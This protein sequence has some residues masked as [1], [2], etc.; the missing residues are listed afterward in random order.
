MSIPSW[1]PT[2]FKLLTQSMVFKDD[3]EHYLPQADSPS[4]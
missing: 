2:T 3:P 1:A 4:A